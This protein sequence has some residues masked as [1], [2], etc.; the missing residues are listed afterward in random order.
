MQFE[1]IN[2]FFIIPKKEV[3][4]INF[5]LESYE[6]IG[7]VT[8]IDKNQALIKIT[9]SPYF[10]NEFNEIIKDLSTHIEIIEISQTILS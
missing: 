1:S 10:I 8:T 5:I 6:H 9:I 3:Y 7:F 4:F 2:R